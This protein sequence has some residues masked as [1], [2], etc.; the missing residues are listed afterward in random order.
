M[1]LLLGLALVGFAPVIA[2]EKPVTISE[3]PPKARQAIETQVGSGKLGKITRDVEGCDVTYDVETTR[4]G[5]DRSFTVSES[6]ELLETEVFMRELPRPVARAIRERIG[7]GA[8]DSI[9][10]N[11]AD[12]EVSYDVAF[13]KE[14][15]E[16]DFSL[17]A[18]GGLLD[19]Q[20]FLDEVPAAVNS[21]IQKQ[22]AAGMKA[23]DVYRTSE[24]GKVYYEVEFERNGKARTVA[25]GEKGVVAYEDE[26]V[27]FTD[28]PQA[29][30]DAAKAS[31]G[32][33]KPCSVNKHAEGDVVSYDIEFKKDGKTDSVTIAADGKAD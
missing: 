10:K 27:S 9:F 4:D 31:I 3:L 16:R 32:D 11:H 28:L 20:V 26:S 30:R 15:K 5:R 2:A 33:A 19:E 24:E 8:P 12:G 13:T 1:L 14:G 22:V 18:K 21:A 17:D 7:R 29:A 25:F 23:G 6:G